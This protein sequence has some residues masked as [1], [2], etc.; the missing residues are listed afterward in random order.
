MINDIM[1]KA[2][3]ISGEIVGWRRAL[4]AIPECGYELEETCA[5][6][7]SVLHGIGIEDIR[8]GVGRSGIVADICGGLGEGR[9][10]ALR[11]DMD[12]LPMQEDNDLPYRSRHAGKMHACGHDGHTA[13]LL[14]AAKLAWA[15]RDNF[16]G[17]V[18]FIFQ[19][20]EEGGG[21]ARSMI[22]DGVLD[23][24]DAVF[25]CHLVPM[26]GLPAGSV[27]FQKGV[28]LSASDRIDIT[29]LGRGGHGSAPQD[30]TDAVTLAA[31][32]VNNLQY[33]V[34]RQTDPRD[35]LC[36]TVGTLHAGTA[37]NVIA[38]SAELGISMR[39]F[40]QEVREKA[41][42]DIERCVK[43][44]CDGVGASYEMRVHDGI[45]ALVCDEASAELME[46]ACV[47]LI[48]R[49]K[50]VLMKEPGSASDDF[51]DF[52]AER[53]GAYY[54]LCCCSGEDTSFP[55]HSPKYKMDDSVLYIGSSVDL[56]IINRFLNG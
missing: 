29:L 37:P 26:D 49:E 41:L 51:A 35:A 9:T 10:L 18:R 23:G 1:R 38:A 50:T 19:P 24:V 46:R 56:G 15:E 14:G 48:G 25:G 33:I 12:A 34:S 4:H 31:Q 44:V 16:R 2:E 42:R 43:A 17:K 20:A 3:A 36:L 27:F 6:V 5:F 55:P 30:A 45:R 53:P 52:L 39:S 7:E 28:A 54:Q 21:G 22:K 32:V 11:A 47:E 8:T 40:R 13:M